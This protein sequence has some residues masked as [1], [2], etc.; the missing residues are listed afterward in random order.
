MLPWVQ[1]RERESLGHTVSIPSTKVSGIVVIEGATK[2]VK[3]TNYI[4]S[5]YVATC[6]ANKTDLHIVYS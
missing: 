2:E 1:V 3:S 5:V 6:Y 4:V